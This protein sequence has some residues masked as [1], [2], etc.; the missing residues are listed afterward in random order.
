MAPRRWEARQAKAL[1]ERITTLVNYEA[2]LAQQ[3]ASRS[4][5][6]WDQAT[7]AVAFA[8][9]PSS[10]S[11]GDK[12]IINDSSGPTYRGTASGGGSTVAPVVYDGANWVYA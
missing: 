8:D 7:T 2:S 11:Q 6:Q 12:A 4:E 5:S 3:S 10:P 9:L 1:A